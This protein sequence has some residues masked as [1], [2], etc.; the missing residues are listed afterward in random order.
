MAAT[1]EHLF[2]PGQSGN[3]AGRP[4]GS[5]NKKQLTE[6]FLGDLAET[7]SRRGMQALEEVA[8]TK[9]V[10]FCKIA[11]SLIPKDMLVTVDSA[12]SFVISAVPQLTTEEWQQK[13]GL[14]APQSTESASDGDS[15]G[16]VAV[17][18]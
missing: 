2:S 18:D 11:A 4:K 10:E 16:K 1:A 6:A 14:E 8:T 12:E 13:H 9:P 15:K 5:K 3:P 17:E 7:W